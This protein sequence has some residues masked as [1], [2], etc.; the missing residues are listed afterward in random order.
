MM[1]SMNRVFVDSSLQVEAEKGNFTEILHDLYF[2][3]TVSLCTNDI[4]L[5]EFL[6]H[7]IRLQTGKSP[8]TVKEKK[9]ISQIIDIYNKDKILSNFEFIASSVQMLSV[10][11]ELMG[12]YNLLPHD[13]IILATCKI[14][15]ITMLANS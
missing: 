13:A 10:V 9:E 6:F 15:N 2:N 14:N 3:S 5:S 7:F 1:F 12:K 11:P 4:V 8:M